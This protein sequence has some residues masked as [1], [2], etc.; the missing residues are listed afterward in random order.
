MSTFRH[1]PRARPLALRM[2]V[3]A[4]WELIT[5]CGQGPRLTGKEAETLSGEHESK[6]GG[7]WDELWA[8]GLPR[9]AEAQRC[10]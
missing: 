4:S 10:A 8:E 9:G 1:L 3:L 2:Y 6:S 5:E 7:V